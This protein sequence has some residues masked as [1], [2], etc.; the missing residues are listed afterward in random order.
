VSTDLSLAERDAQQVFDRYTAV[1]IQSA[2]S[3]DLDPRPLSAFLALPVIF[4]SDEGHLTATTVEQLAALT[5]QELR[6]LRE[7]D[8]GGT[9]IL[10]K[11]VRALNA[12]AVVIEITWVRRDVRGQEFQRSGSH[13]L[14][15]RTDDGWRIVA[16]SL[17]A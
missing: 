5:V 12:C 6:Q 15:A 8:Y 4:T 13:Y 10:T 2:A 14:M 11:S 7:N 9:D 17:V 1:F 16:V 3:G